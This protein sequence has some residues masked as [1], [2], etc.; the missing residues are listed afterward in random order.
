MIERL[1]EDFATLAITGDMFLAS[2]YGFARGF[3]FYVERMDDA[4]NAEASKIL[5]NSVRKEIEREGFKKQFYFLHTYQ[6]HNI[7]AP[8]PELIRLHYGRKIK[9]FRFNTMNFIRHGKA[10]CRKVSREKLQEIRE[11]YN[12]GVFTFDYRFGEFINY[13]KKKGI[14]DKSLIALFSDHGEEFA[15]HGCWEHG[16]SLYNELIK[17]PLII[18]LPGGRYKGKRV[19]KN[20]SIVDILPT[21]LDY[22]GKKLEKDV[23]GI[24]LLP[25]IRGRRRSDRVLFAYLAPYS[26]RKH[27]PG[28]ISLIKGKYKLIYNEEMKPEDRKFFLFPPVLK[29][30]YEF[31]DLEKD[32]LERFNIRRSTPEKIQLR[33]ILERAWREAMRSRQ[34][35]LPEELKKKL[36]S[37]GYL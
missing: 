9:R 6:I 7:Y 36:R 2:V 35:R 23:D 30:K 18:K 11:T 12:A 13:L 27:I 22:C 10:L 21:V 17:I 25:A 5:F 24:S 20:V 26:L 33:N 1:S 16:H 15:E 29:D 14:Y 28:K 31:Y 4:V 34:G 19:Y 3:D 8:E 32:E 37:I